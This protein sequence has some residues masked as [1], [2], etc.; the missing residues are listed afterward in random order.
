MKLDREEFRKRITNTDIF[1][2]IITTPEREE[3]MD[4]LAELLKYSTPNPLAAAE[5]LEDCAKYF[6]KFHEIKVDM[7]NEQGY[8]DG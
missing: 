5:L 4:N 2:K 1:K 7:A 6:K 3:F 8:L